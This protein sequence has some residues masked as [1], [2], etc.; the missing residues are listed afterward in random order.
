MRSMVIHLH[1]AV[2]VQY[3]REPSDCWTTFRV[4]GKNN[5]LLAEIVVFNENL[6]VET[7]VPVEETPS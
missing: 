6:G 1:G 3:A 2:K 4:R 7:G 5:E